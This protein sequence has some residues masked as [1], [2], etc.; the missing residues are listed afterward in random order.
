MITMHDTKFKSQG[1]GTAS[2]LPPTP[3]RFPTEVI[4]ALKRMGTG[5]QDYIRAAVL[6]ALKKDNL[7]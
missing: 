6:A 1:K 2:K 4:E 5:K 3:V 7:L